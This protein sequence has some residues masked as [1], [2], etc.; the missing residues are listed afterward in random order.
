M[1]SPFEG[2][3]QSFG[4]SFIMM[5]CVRLFRSPSSYAR[6]MRNP[7]ASDRAVA[8]WESEHWTA[9]IAAGIMM[10]ASSVIQVLLAMT[11]VKVW[12]DLF[13]GFGLMLTLIAAEEASLGR[14]RTGV[15]IAAS[16]VKVV[17]AIVYLYFALR[18]L[19]GI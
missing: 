4:G 14:R 10:T 12:F 11:Q 2:C 17:V 13:C 8:R 3:L 1:E 18:N 5:C 9:R 19:R 16:I 15:D 6:N 7:F